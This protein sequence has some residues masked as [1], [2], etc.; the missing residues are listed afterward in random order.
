M[1]G[2]IGDGTVFSVPVSGG[3][4]TTLAS[5]SSSNGRRPFGSLTLIGS[6]LYGTTQEGG[7]NDEGTVFSVPVSGGPPPPWP[8]LAAAMAI[9]PLAV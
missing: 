3:A 1:G 4:P 9:F 8:R 5:F 7:A 2:A 6:T